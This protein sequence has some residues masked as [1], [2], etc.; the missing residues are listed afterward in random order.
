MTTELRDQ[1]QTTM[2]DAYRLERELGGGGM[3]WRVARSAG[4]GPM[5]REG[6]Q[7]PGGTAST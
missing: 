6:R 2:G 1:L 7:S 4:R 3:E 5:P